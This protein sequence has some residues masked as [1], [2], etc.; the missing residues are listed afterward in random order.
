MLAR[1][2]NAHPYRI[3]PDHIDA[4]QHNA[5]A[6]VGLQPPAAFPATSVA[7]TLTRKSHFS[8]SEPSRRACK[9]QDHPEHASYREQTT[10]GR[11]AE[12][13]KL[14]R[15]YR[16]PLG[17]P[18]TMAVPLGARKATICSVQR[19]TCAA[20][21]AASIRCAQHVALAGS[22]MRCFA[23]GATRARLRPCIANHAA[24]AAAC[25]H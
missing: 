15:L 1:Q 21:G 11:A 20:P 13:A 4:Q 2:N 25:K 14:R 8:Q 5:T 23:C 7:A 9:L 10:L 18:T 19:S 24:P 6:M 22:G 17:K 16:F 12:S 3:R